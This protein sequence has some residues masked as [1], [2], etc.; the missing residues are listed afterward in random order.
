[1]HSFFTFLKC[2][3]ITRRSSTHT[4]CA[5]QFVSRSFVVLLRKIF[6]QNRNLQTAAEL[7]V[8]QLHYDYEIFS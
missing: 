4:S 7:G 8:M 5:G 3:H 6:S 2:K 1:M